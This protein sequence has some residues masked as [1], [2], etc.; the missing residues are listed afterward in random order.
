MKC[1]S[2]ATTLGLIF[3]HGRKGRGLRA[4]RDTWHRKLFSGNAYAAG[5]KSF[6]PDTL[7]SS[8]RAAK[9]LD[10]AAHDSQSSKP[11]HMTLVHRR[12]PPLAKSPLPPF[13]KG[14][15]ATRGGICPRRSCVRTLCGLIW[16]RRHQHYGRHARLCTV[17]PSAATSYQ[18]LLHAR[19]KSWYTFVAHISFS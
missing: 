6:F 1:W 8:G 5:M 15:S 19:L 4:V 11:N 13:I 18:C 14:E 16:E 7:V 9:L 2:P 3:S 12:V 17:M 10:L